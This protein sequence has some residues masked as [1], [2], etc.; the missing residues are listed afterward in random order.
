MFGTF[1]KKIKGASARKFL[2]TDTNAYIQWQVESDGDARISIHDGRHTITFSEWVANIDQKE[3][4]NFDK[5]M[6]LIVD[7]INALRKAVKSKTAKK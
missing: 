1:G 6:G 5:K 4:L 7:E 3:L 2:S